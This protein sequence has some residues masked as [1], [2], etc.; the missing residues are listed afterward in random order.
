MHNY[1]CCVLMCTTGHLHVGKGRQQHNYN[2]RMPKLHNMQLC[3]C[4]ALGTS[5]VCALKALVSFCKQTMNWRANPSTIY[6]LQ[7]V[8]QK[9]TYRK[10]WM[11]EIMTMA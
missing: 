5:G 10:K 11:H 8:G 1:A 4:K 6:K 2:T 7:R 9:P 3:R